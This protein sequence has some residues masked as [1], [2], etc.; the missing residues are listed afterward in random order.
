MTG[1]RISP[2]E[3]PGPETYL[4]SRWD[5]EKLKH[6]PPRVIV[7]EDDQGEYVYLRVDA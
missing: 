5:N 3:G 7:V 6:I 4:L 2:G 1:Y